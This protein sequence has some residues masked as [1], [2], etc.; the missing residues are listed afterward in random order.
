MLEALRRNDPATTEA[1]VRAQIPRARAVALRLLRNE[2]EADDAVQEAF[3]QAFR[4]LSDFRGDAKL[5]TWLH[6]I[7]VNAALGRLRRRSRKPEVELDLAGPEFS[8]DGHLTAREGARWGQVERLFESEETRA[9]MRRMIDQLP[10]TAR[11]VL[12]LR[13][14]EELSTAEA[15]EALGVSPGTVKTRLHRARVAL[16]KRV[17]QALDVQA[18]D[19]GD[20]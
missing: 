14:I 1:W 2:A 4:R 16:K 12:I 17:E 19:G 18:E 7:V 9:L 10:E 6:R 11:T 15:A 5:E 13:D 8:A 20:A 3:M